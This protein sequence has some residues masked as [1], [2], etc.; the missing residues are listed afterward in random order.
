MAWCW[1][2]GS[3]AVTADEADNARPV[4]QSAGRQCLARQV[5]WINNG[6]NPLV[7]ESG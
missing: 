2:C 5:A 1:F 7:K 6:G 4:V 3:D